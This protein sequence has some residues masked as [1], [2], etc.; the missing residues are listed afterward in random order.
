MIYYN[1]NRNYAIK[2]LD[3]RKYVHLVRKEANDLY[4]EQVAIEDFKRDW[5]EDTIHRP[6]NVITVFLKAN[7]LSRT[8]PERNRA[9]EALESILN[10]LENLDKRKK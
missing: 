5:V 2:I 10:Q 4:I 6:I 9:Y 7:G 1:A 3:G 8:K